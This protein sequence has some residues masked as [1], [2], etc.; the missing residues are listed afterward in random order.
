MV[1]LRGVQK[2]TTFKGVL[3]PN[4]YEEVDEKVYFKK[5]YDA[6]VQDLKT[7]EFKSAYPD[8]I[9]LL[10]ASG[11]AQFLDSP[12]KEPVKKPVKEPIKKGE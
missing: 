1:K 2:N 12:V 8:P 11:K 7:K 5:V 10:R 6:K 3:L 4:D 9:A